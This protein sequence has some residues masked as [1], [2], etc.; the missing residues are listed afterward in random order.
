MTLS[1]TQFLV[2]HPALTRD[3]PP[4]EG[5]QPLRSLKPRLGADRPASLC[6]AARTAWRCPHPA[7]WPSR[8]RRHRDGSTGAPPTT[9]ARL[10]RAPLAQAGPVAAA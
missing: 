2:G 10:S 4:G 6:P 1:H 8:A 3:P 5:P 9:V 7:F